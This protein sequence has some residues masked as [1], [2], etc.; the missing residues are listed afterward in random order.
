MYGDVV[1]NGWAR[2]REGC[3]IKVDLVG[4]E[5]QVQ[6]GEGWRSI[7][8]LVLDVEALR[9]LL[10]LGELAVRAFDE[11]GDDEVVEQVTA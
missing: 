7:T 1:V 10:R 3:P 6:F 5:A 2:V 8:E 11:A 4:D 9:E